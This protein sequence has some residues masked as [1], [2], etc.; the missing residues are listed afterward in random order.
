LVGADEELEK[1]VATMHQPYQNHAPKKAGDNV[2]RSK[3]D[4]LGCATKI[5][6]EIG[7]PRNLFSIILTVLTN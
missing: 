5:A 4:G 1:P 3:Y 7:F 2:Q 6:A